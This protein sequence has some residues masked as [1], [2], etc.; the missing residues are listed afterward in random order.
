MQHKQAAS[1][2]ETAWAPVSL[3]VAEFYQRTGRKDKQAFYTMADTCIAERCL[4]PG[5]RKL[6]QELD[7]HETLFV[8]ASLHDVT[9]GL[10]MET[11]LQLTPRG[12][13]LLNRGLRMLFVSPYDGDDDEAIG[14]NTSSDPDLSLEHQRRWSGA[15]IYHRNE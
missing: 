11:Y 14:R 4:Q 9:E 1:S 6:D 12:L 3:V 15:A 2:F 5:R 7:E 10:S 13:M 8:V